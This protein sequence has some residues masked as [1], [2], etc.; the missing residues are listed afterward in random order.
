MK[1]ISL[2]ILIFS[3]TLIHA[4]VCP[5][6]ASRSCY[7]ALSNQYSHSE[8]VG[9]CSNVADSCFRDFI[10]ELGINKTISFCHN[11][12]ATCYEEVRAQKAGGY[13][14]LV[15]ARNLCKNVSNRCYIDQRFANYSIRYSISYCYDR[16]ASCEV[17]SY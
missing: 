1:T 8:R 6:D 13:Y 14:Q 2:I 9:I 3:S 4:Q 11:V 5:P 17:C 15:R 10:G 7:N 16:A 12:A